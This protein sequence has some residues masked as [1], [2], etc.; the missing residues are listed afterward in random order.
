LIPEG[1]ERLGV[2]GTY[3]GESGGERR[4]KN[5]AKEKSVLGD[6]SLPISVAFIFDPRGVRNLE[7]FAGFDGELLETSFSFKGSE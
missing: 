2:P 4:N 5:R 7:H 6:K 1:T 3:S